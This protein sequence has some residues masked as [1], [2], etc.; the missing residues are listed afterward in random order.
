MAD[1]AKYEP[2]MLKRIFRMFE[3][4]SRTPFGGIGKPEAL[5]GN[6]SSYCGFACA[7]KN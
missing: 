3:E 1:W 7:V 4:C 5:K 6:L 2:N